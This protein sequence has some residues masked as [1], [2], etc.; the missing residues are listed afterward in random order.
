LLARCTHKSHCCE[1]REAKLL[2]IITSHNFATCSHSVILPAMVK[3]SKEKQTPVYVRSSEHAWVPALQL[4]TYNGKATVSIPKFQSEKELMNCE[5]A[6]RKF[7]YQDN[8]I[9]DLKD[10]PNGLLPMQNVDANGRLEDYAEMVDLPCMSEV[11][12]GSSAELMDETLTRLSH[13]AI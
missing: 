8:Q 3:E 12:D 7:R 10:Y 1:Y 13:I 2:T 6:S 5:P 11:S 9:V 4:K